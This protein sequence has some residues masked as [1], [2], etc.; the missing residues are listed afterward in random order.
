LPIYTRRG[1]DY[2]PGDC[3]YFDNPQF[4]PKTPQWR[5][6]NVIDLGNDLYFGHGIGIK[7]AD[8]IIESLNKRRKAYATESAY[9]LSQVTR[10]DNRY[11]YQF[12]NTRA[13]IPTFLASKTI[14]SKLGSA[15]FYH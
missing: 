14:V 15:T 12:S 11:L 4:N 5:G 8:G 2:L 13:Q 7:T 9:L 10:L 3:L 6:E 1:N